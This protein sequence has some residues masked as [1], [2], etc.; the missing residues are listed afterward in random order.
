MQKVKIP[1]T[2]NPVKSA[3]HLLSYDGEIEAVKLSRLGEV[4]NKIIDTVAVQIHCN[5][6]EQGLVVIN[7]HV[8]TK[9]LVTCQRCNDDLGL[10]LELSFSY[11][12]IDMGAESESLPDIYEAVELNEDGEVDIH[13]LVEDEL[14]LI[15]PIVPMHEEVSCSFSAEPKSFGVLEEKD[16]KP[17]PFDILKQLKKDS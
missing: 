13:R 8:K 14:I 6:D 5:V 2:I 16:D 17:N 10:D 11:S 3:Q 7:G 4:T 12:P 9:A 1:I 15:I